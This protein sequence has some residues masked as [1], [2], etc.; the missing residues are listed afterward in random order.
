MAFKTVSK[1]HNNWLEGDSDI[2][3]SGS[4]VEV[5]SVFGIHFLVS[6]AAFHRASAC[7]N[8]LTQGKGD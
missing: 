3:Q 4:Y 6:V 8:D 7:L 5:I 2:Y 1:A